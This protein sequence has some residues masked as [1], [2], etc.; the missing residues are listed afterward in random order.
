MMVEAMS[1]VKRDI[2]DAASK[3]LSKIARAMAKRCKDDGL[4]GHVV[5]AW[6]TADYCNVLVAGSAL[7]DALRTRPRGQSAAAN[8]KADM[9]LQ[10]LMTDGR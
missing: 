9:L 3:Q 6:L 8:K 10:G 2:S 7:T 5:P 1:L 4:D